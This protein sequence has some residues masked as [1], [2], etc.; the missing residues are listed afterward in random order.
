MLII[1]TG[2]QFG[3]K[4]EIFGCVV[5][6]QLKTTLRNIWMSCFFFKLKTTLG[7]IWV[8][9]FFSNWEPLSLGHSCWD[10]SFQLGTSAW[11]EISKISRKSNLLKKICFRIFDWLTSAETVKVYLG[12]LSQNS[13]LNSNFFTRDLPTDFFVLFWTSKTLLLQYVYFHKLSK[14]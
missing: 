12:K 3:R 10:R 4:L 8:C 13:I 6:L 1:L 11:K 5:F 7:N 14:Q 2:H 9:C